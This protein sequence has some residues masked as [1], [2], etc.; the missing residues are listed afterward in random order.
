MHR[1]ILS[2]KKMKEINTIKICIVPDFP[3]ISYGKS[4]KEISSG[5]GEYCYNFLLHL[6]KLKTPYYFTIFTTRKDAKLLPKLNNNFRIIKTK[7]FIDTPLMHLFWHFIV[8]PRY[9]KRYKIDLLHLLSGNRYLPLKVKCPMIA[10]VY[11]LR[12]F[13]IKNLYGYKNYFYFKHILSRLI[14]KAD[15][16]LSISQSTAD[17]LMHFLGINASRIKVIHMAY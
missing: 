4:G 13:K 8:L 9:V 1:L 15:Y 12:K 5:I 17:D 16:I 10:T 11:D 14:S 6:N 3:D 2:L 7:Y